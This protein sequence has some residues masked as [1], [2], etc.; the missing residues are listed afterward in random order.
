[1]E[2]D[3]LQQLGQGEPTEET[4]EVKPEEKKKSSGKPLDDEVIASMMANGDNT[5]GMFEPD[6]S[7][8]IDKD[9]KEKKHE[10]Q[11]EKA[12]LKTKGDAKPSDKY[13]DKF[14]ED[15][16]KNPEKYFIDTPK[17]RMSIKEAKEQGYDPTT[18]R[19][20]KKNNSR[21]EM[22]SQVNETD[23]EAIKKLM[24]P[25]QLGLAPADAE[26]L[27]VK[28]DSP[29]VRTA[30]SQPSPAQVPTPMSPPTAGPAPTG[31]TPDINALLGGNA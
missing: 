25:S 19:F 4:P 13:K 30:M 11:D 2:E 27:G 7:E 9:K 1:M 16:A 10:D 21:E 18:R 6:E 24:D 23:R 3:I 20:K 29:M 14:K 12:K 17:G 22:L 31:G 28:P 15:M 8:V 5:R 26:G